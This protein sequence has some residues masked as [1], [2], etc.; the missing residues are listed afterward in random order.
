MTSFH[1]DGA[2]PACAITARISSTDLRRPSCAPGSAALIAACS[3]PLH[4]PSPRI[5]ATVQLITRSANPTSFARTVRTTIFTFFCCA[6][7][8]SWSAWGAS[9]LNT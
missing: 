4:S 6:M 9:P 1:C 5:Q 3:E 7:V 2:Y 8:N